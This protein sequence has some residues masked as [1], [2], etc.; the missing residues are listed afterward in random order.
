MNPRKALWLIA[1]AALCGCAVG[2]NYHRPAAP[3]PEHFKEQEGWKPAEPKD[4]ASGTDWWSVYDDSVLDGLEKQIDISNQTLKAS[5]AS[6][7]EAQAVV[8]QA[9]AGLFPTFGVSGAATR[10]KGLGTTI[11]GNTTTTTG[12]GTTTTG[13]SA[14]TVVPTTSHPVNNFNATANA[15]WAP[16]IWGKIRR[17]IESDVA[18]ALASEADL[19]AARLSAQGTLATDYVELRISDETKQLLDQTVEAYQRS[20]QI[21]QNQYKAGIVAKADVITAETQLEGAQSQQINVGVMRAQLE[22]AIAV[23]VGKPP[24]D[25]SIVPGAFGTTIPVSPTGIPSSLLE[26]RPDVAAAERTMASA[27][28]QI[29]VAVAAYFP[30]LTLTGTYGFT[31]SMINGLLRAPNNVW[32]LGADVSDTIL[33]FGARSAQVAQARAAYDLAV[34]NYRQAVLTAFQQVEDELAALRILEQQDKVQDETV[35]SANEAVRLVLN[36]YKA[37]IVAYTS[38]VT[39]QA[40]ALADAQTLL[41]IRQNRLTASVALIQA[42]GGGWSTSALGTTHEAAPPAPN[43]NGAT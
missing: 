41:S 16:D 24:A 6:W 25:F 31:S 14:T 13:G 39:A 5:E 40:T 7:R 12:G 43:T 30:D 29:G 3:V 9:R 33:D 34:A 36:E 22:H 10:T 26:R 38:V 15:S 35:K 8:S 32:S 23:L 19:A 20:L 28:A 4:A 11:G 21:T 42:L 2:P 27:N 37:G 17:T 18:S 1:T